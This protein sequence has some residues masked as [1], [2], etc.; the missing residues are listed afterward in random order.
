MLDEFVQDPPK[1]ALPQRN[2]PVEA[3]GLDRADDAAACRRIPR[4][5]GDPSARCCCVDDF[6]RNG[7][8]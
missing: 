1:V 3:F 6:C 5:S 4:R 7:P 2:Y 8:A